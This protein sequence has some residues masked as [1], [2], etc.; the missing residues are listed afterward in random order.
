MR[1]KFML[2]LAF[3]VLSVQMLLAQNKVL[4]G[5]VTDNNGAPIA[6]ASIME[7]GTNHGTITANDGSFSLTVSDKSKTLVVSAVGYQ[8]QDLAISGTSYQISLKTGEA[9]SL[10]EVVVVG[11]GT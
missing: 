7:K 3:I 1:K 8:T 10:N 4:T 11:F 6:G 9:Q 5:K 2:V